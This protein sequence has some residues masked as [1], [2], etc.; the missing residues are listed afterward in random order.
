MATINDFTQYAVLRSAARVDESAALREVAEQFEALFVQNMLKSMREASFGD[1]LFGDSSGSQMF[2]DMFDQQIA[3]DIA[4]G[5]GGGIGLADL[6]VRQMS[7]EH[8]NVATVD[9][10][11]TIT[12]TQSVT[13]AVASEWTDAQQFVA[14]VLPHAKR[15]AK[16]LGVSPLAII[17]QSALETGWGKRVMKTQDGESSNNLFGIKALGGWQGDV[18]SHDTIEFRDGLASQQREPFRSYRSVAASFE[19]YKDLIGNSTRYTPA[20]ER[21]DDVRG[22]ADALQ[23]GGYATDPTYAD[24]IMRIASGTTMRRVLGA[25]K[26]SDLLSLA[27]RLGSNTTRP[28]GSL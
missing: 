1:P 26:E 2:R 6:L 18:V 17:A 16:A 24:K 28:E 27:G 13:G 8:R 23:A 19:D 15:A 20:T 4:S 9:R 14:D 7:S 10:A 11:Q 25:L 5:S 12:A 21:A 3:G 22:Y